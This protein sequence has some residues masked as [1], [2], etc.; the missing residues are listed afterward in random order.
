MKFYISRDDL[1]RIKQE[2]APREGGN[3]TSLGVRIY[4]S[5]IA[6]PGLVE[7]ETVTKLTPEDVAECKKTW[8]ETIQAMG[9]PRNFVM[10]SEEQ[11]IVRAI[12]QHG[13]EPVSLALFGA[14]FEPVIEHFDP[15]AHIDICR[16][17]LNDKLGK[18]RIQKFVEYGARGKAKLKAEQ[19]KAE[20]RQAEE[21]VEEGVPPPEEVRKLL[22]SHGFGS[23][24]K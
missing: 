8:L 22:A 24:P 12:Q 18:P 6:E 15:R 13:V 11:L 5:P 4:F 7:C 23:M 9:S 1:E 3:L 16:I 21:A 19:E 17:L 14:R 20:K 2:S 10:A